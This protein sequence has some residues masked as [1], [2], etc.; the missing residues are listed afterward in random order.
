VRLPKQQKEFLEN[1][2]GG[3]FTNNYEE[4]AWNL[5]ETIS[6]NTGNWGLDK[7]NEPHLEYEYSYVKSFSTSTVFEHLSD[8]FGLHP[9]VLVEIAKIFCWSYWCT[10]KSI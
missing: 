7:G 1:S 9:D 2:S 10:Q 4:E 3:S 6:K 5:L 8:K